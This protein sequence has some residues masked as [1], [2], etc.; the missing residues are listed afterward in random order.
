MH[1]DTAQAVALNALSFILSEDGLKDRFVALSGLD[2]GD[3]RAR[4]SDRDFH[5]S[6]LEFLVNHEPDLIAFAENTNEQ[7]EN[8]VSAWR[9]LGGG[10]GQE[11]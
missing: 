9:V 4:I 11:W 7:P 6:I 3:F 8:V 1:P 5:V 2:G 10:V